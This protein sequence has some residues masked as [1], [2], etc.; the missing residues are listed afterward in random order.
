MKIGNFDLDQDVLVVAEIGNNH[1]GSYALAEDIIG[2]AAKAGVGA[3]KFQTY[4]TEYYVSKKDKARFNRLKS[5]ELT[6]TEFRKLSKVARSEGVLFLSTPFDIESA[7][8]LDEIVSAYKISSGDNNF[9]TLIKRVAQT[10]KPII[11]S[12]GLAT[13]EQIKTAQSLIQQTWSCSGI[14]QELAILHCVTSYPVPPEEANLA[15]I[16]RLKN[17]LKCAV[18][19]SDHTLG[20]DA[21]VLAVALGARIIEK[22]FTINKNYSDFRDHQL[23]ADP[24]QMA[25]LV[26]RI[27]Q[28]SRLLGT[29]EKVIQDSEKSML[30]QARRSIVAKRN[31]AKGTVIEWNDISWIRP[32]EGLSPGQEHLVVG[33]ALART[34][35]MGELLTP[36]LLCEK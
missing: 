21:A 4:K 13:L 20:I 7:E 33:K 22:H 17:E 28:A 36:E 34:V 8:F 14:R 6:H 27:R 3:V 15:A 19:Y 24:H 5:F 23:S 29:G 18:G 11:L 35:K 1:E 10:G 26:A 30:T 9:Y 31:L 16:P 25:R 12:S 2:L 32:A